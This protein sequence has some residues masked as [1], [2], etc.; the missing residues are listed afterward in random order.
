ML[1]LR[2]FDDLRLS[3]HTG[4]TRNHWAALA[5]HV[6]LSAR[7]YASPSHARVSF[8]GPPGGY[9]PDVDAL[10]GF[11]RTFLAAGF[12]VAGE[13]GRDPLGLMEWY[14]QGLAAGTDPRSP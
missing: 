1:M 8:P 6:L 7:R 10:E 5:D 13:G 12:R 3:P 11:A 2:E 4:W 9:G 14:A